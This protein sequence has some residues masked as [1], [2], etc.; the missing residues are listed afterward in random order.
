MRVAQAMKTGEEKI[1]FETV[2]DH[3]S[4]ELREMAEVS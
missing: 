1:G 2:M 4:E 3:A